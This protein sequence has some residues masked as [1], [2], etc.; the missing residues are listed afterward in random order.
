M[1][2][3]YWCPHQVLKATG[4]PLRPSKTSVS[5]QKGQKFEK[6]NFRDLPQASVQ[7][8]GLFRH[9]KPGYQWL[10]IDVRFLQLISLGPRVFQRD[11]KFRG[12]FLL[13]YG[14]KV[15]F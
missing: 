14:L 8:V 5:S 7:N 4:A 11:K 2:I 10:R 6:D 3:L 1:P 13:K 12:H 9:L 15:T